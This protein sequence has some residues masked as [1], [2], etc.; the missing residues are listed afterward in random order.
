MTKKTEVSEDFQLYVIAT[1][2]ADSPLMELESG[3]TGV[4]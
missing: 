2:I 1:E 3:K 4:K